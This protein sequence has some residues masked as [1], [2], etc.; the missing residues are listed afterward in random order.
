MATALAQLHERLAELADLQ[1]ASS[2]LHWDQGVMMPDD[3]AAQ[4]GEALGT[5]AR[6]TH[7]QFT[8]ARTAE[9][10]EAAALEAQALDPDSDDARLVRK[11]R[12]DHERAIRVPA[13]LAA[14]LARA[15]SAGHHAW[16]AAR[17]AD[18]FSMFAP[19]LRRNLELTRAYVDCFDGH[20][21]A[22]DVLLEDYD[23]GT[24]TA[25]VRGLFEQLKARLVPLIARLRDQQI[26]SSVLH[27]AYPVAAQ[28]QLVGEVVRRM[29]FQDS[30]W[31]LDDTVHPFATSFGSGDVRITTRYDA[32][33]FPTALYGAMHECGHGLYNQGVADALQRGWLARPDSLALHE[34]QSRMWENFVG[35]GRAFSELLARRVG[36]LSGG[37][38][39]GLDGQTLYRAVNAVRPSLIRIEADE[40]TYSLHVILRFEL[41]QQLIEGRLAVE[42]LPDA[43]RALMAEY[44]GVEVP[45]DADGVLQDVHW[46]EGLIGY[47]PTYVLGNLIAGHLW[48]C[49][50][51]ALP[52]LEGELAAGEFTS[53]REWLR[54]NVHR[55]GAKYT[56][57]ELLERVAGA[58]LAV[59]PFMN[60]LER[61]LSDVYEVTL[62]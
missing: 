54:H 33:Y 60:Y 57:V 10:I 14:D 29:G 59:E 15:A 45:S 3:G 37:A 34:S 28:R 22:Y 44:L 2:V 19:H 35:R 47:F 40:T 18:D 32:H 51:T 48:E 26:D 20:A 16:V 5:L 8:S 27:V 30:G 7:E 62:A 4:R 13:Q 38:L 31:R 55:H 43:W 42:E 41:E 12:H 24:T 21:E 53:L 49:A 23:A 9:L 11:V 6:L 17:A 39:D 46:S 36:E 61:K 1:H 52:A 56:S 50:H 25:T 58:P